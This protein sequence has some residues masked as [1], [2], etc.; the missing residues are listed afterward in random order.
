MFSIFVYLFSAV[1]SFWASRYF[2][3]LWKKNRYDPYREFSAF[4]FFLGLSFLSPLLLFFEDTTLSFAAGELLTF[5]VLFSF[6]FVLRTFV[7]FQQISFLSYQAVSFIAILASLV[8]TGVGVYYSEIPEIKDGLIYW[9]YALPH[10]IVYLTLLTCYTGAMGITLLSH[11]NSVSKRKSQIF[12][13]GAGFLTGGMGG[14]FII[15]FNSFLF[16][17]FGFLLL[18]ITFIFVGLFILTSLREKEGVN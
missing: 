8:G 17:L 1:I 15:G 3:S 11:L 2:F 5:F 12:Y 10:I 4:F 18:F 13:L 14:F 16:S 6:A 9:H 7:R